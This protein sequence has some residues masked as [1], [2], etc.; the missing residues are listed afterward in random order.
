MVLSGGLVAPAAVD[1]QEFVF[2]DRDLT[3]GERK[4]IRVGLREFLCAGQGTWRKDGGVKPKPLGLDS[5]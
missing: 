2:G 5:E 1:N 4:E 3:P